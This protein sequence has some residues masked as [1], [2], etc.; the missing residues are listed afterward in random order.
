MN[1][2]EYLK[3]LEKELNFLTQ[4]ELTKEIECYKK[5][6]NSEEEKKVEF[7][8]T[9]NSLGTPKE[10]SKKIYLKRGIDPSKLKRNFI[11]SIITSVI[12]IIN[13]FKNPKN[14]RK[15][16]ILDLIYMFL[17][18]ILVKL[19]FNLVRDIG[20]DYILIASKSILIENL[21]YLLFLVLYTITALCIFIV[22][23]RGF[24]KKYLCE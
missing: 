18:I 1:K 19:P 8:D 12:N 15:N 10:L 14:E 6:F 4:E 17:V 2:E 21:W 22:L 11:N 20:Y 24:N 9:I 7:V 16:M 23:A 5:F 13:A 3:R